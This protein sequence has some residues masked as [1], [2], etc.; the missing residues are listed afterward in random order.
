MKKCSSCKAD[1]P[2]GAKFCRKCGKPLKT[3]SY[4]STKKP[5][6]KKA[7][8]KGTALAIALAGG[9]GFSLYDNTPERQYQKNIAMG[10]KYLEKYNF[11]K[12]E[13]YL[14][15]AKSIDPKNEEV[16]EDL[17]KV[18]EAQG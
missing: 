16:Y 9:I 7:I 2:D 18:Y 5:K 14:M 11:E 3:V 15:M 10:E 6:N 8:Y 17:V 1:N 4:S 13:E 12:A